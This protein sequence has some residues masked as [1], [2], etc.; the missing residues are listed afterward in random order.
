[1][2]PIKRP[3]KYGGD[4]ELPEGMLSQLKYPIEDWGN[5]LR[6]VIHPFRTIGSWLR[7]SRKVLKGVWHSTF[8]KR[9][10]YRP[11]FREY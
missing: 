6:I 11:N 1:M 3:E 4:D 7:F 5:P 10:S 8:R 9:G 2:P